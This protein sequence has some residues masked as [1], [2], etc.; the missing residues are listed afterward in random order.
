MPVLEIKDLNISYI[1]SRGEQRVIV[2]DGEIVVNKGELVL[3]IGEN[4]SGKSSI[5]RSIVGDL[6]DDD[7]SLSKIVSSFKNLFKKKKAKFVNSKTMV[8]NGRPI[9]DDASLTYLRKSIGFSRQEDD[10]DSFFER[11][12]WDYILDYISKATGYEK[13]STSELDKIA[14]EVYDRLK[15]DKYCEGNLKKSRLKKC[16]GG[17]KKIVSLLAALSRRDSELFILD[18]PIN[19]LDA[20]HA[21]LLNN[22]LV[23]LKNSNNKPGILIITHCPMF[24]DVDRVYELKKGRLVEAERGSYQ[25]KSCYGICDKSLKKYVEEE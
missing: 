20:Y 23:D 8:F 9:D 1:D 22:Y 2:N 11:K 14:Q 24:L 10:I 3:L 7:F 25:T 4:G 16:S 13:K 19:N 18:E 21:R 5:F 6:S 15:G 12:T 17:E